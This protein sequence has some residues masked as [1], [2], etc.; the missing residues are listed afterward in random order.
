MI[1]KDDV[2]LLKLQFKWLNNFHYT[3]KTS[4]EDCKSYIPGIIM[5]I[6]SRKNYEGGKEHLLIVTFFLYKKAKL[7]VK[8]KKCLYTFHLTNE[9]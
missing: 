7:T 1:H 5:Y 9:F 3:T 2:E 8:F 4:T 6:Q